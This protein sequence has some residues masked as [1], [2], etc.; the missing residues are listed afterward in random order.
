MP[1]GMQIVGDIV[2]RGGL[3]NHSYTIVV[4]FVSHLMKVIGIVRCRD[5]Y[6]QFSLRPCWKEGSSAL[7]GG[8]WRPV[9]S[10]SSSAASICVMFLFFFLVLLFFKTTC[11]QKSIYHLLLYPNSY[12]HFCLMENQR[13]PIRVKIQHVIT[14]R[15]TIQHQDKYL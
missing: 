5:I 13:K 11:Y 2:T 8:A 15:A 1:I 4:G 7:P 10:A 12:L 14:H 9:A 3:Y 6:P